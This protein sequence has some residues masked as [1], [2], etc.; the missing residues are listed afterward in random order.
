M[1]ITHNDNCSKHQSHL[2]LQATLSY[3][4]S[5][6]ICWIC[7]DCKSSRGLLAMSMFIACIQNYTNLCVTMTVGLYLPSG[8]PYQVYV[9]GQVLLWPDRLIEN[10]WSG[11][12]VGKFLP[13]WN[14]MTH[15]PCQSTSGNKRMWAD[16]PRWP[17][18]CSDFLGNCP[19]S[20][21]WRQEQ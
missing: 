2:G 6:R 4:T 1:K 7:R 10:I 18:P 3:S 16:S 14:E 15:F 5:V 8:H 13:A 11:Y 20:G 9:S 19:G 17:P 12:V 21:A